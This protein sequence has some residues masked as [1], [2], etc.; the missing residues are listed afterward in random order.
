MIRTAVNE[1]EEA[2]MSRFFHGLNEDVQERIEMV[3][4]QDLQELVH[5]AIRVEQQLKRRQNHSQTYTSSTWSGSV[6]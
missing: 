5:Q 3:T 6:Q 4:Y 1:P 2:T